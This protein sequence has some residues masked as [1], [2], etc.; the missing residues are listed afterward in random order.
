M[1]KQSRKGK[2]KLFHPDAIATEIHQALFRDFR[3]AQ[4]EYCLNDDTV[5]YALNRQVNEL[6]KKY[7]AT[8]YDKKA[9]EE[10]TYQKFLDVNSHIGA[11][12]AELTEYFDQL[13]PTRINQHTLPVDSIFIRARALAHF[14]LGPTCCLEDVFCR[15][16]HSSGS[17]VGVPY[18]D[19][20]LERKWRLPVTVTERVKPLMSDYLDWDESLTIAVDKRRG[21]PSWGYLS[22]VEG[23]RATTVD[24]NNEIRRFCCPEPTGNMYLQQGLMQLMFERFASVGLN[25]PDLP[26]EHKERAR[27]ASLSGNEATIDWSSAS[28]CVS[29]E[30]LRWLLPAQWYRMVMDLRC[31]VTC[32]N[33]TQVVELNMVSTMG[34]ATTFPLETLVFW[35]LGHAVRLYL[36]GSR[37]LFPEWDELKTVSV[38]GDD[39]I[40]PSYCASLFVEACESVGFIINKEKSFVDPTFRFRESCGGDYLAGYDVRPFYLKAPTSTSLSALEPWLYIIGNSLLQKYI[41]YFGPLSYIYHSF[42]STYFEVFRRFKLKLKLV[43]SY[44]PDDAGFKGGFDLQRFQRLYDVN[45]DVVSRSEQG[46]YQFRYCRF[47]YWQNTGWND[48]LRLATWLKDQGFMPPWR[49]PLHQSPL[50]KRGG[51]VV[52]KAISAHWTLPA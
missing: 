29:T 46:T 20:S 25:L 4:H 38:F 26:D 37:S 41:S 45:Y 49:K 40:V 5:L 52:G 27:L 17:S 36:D 9:A 19:T 13:K 11:V 35:T 39:C 23:S 28:D 42:W 34:N 16:K 22:V 3:E 32:I 18:K 6:Q 48:E 1:K 47:V 50:R 12:N 7:L 24:K 31:D 51:Y 2:R 21:T 10:R 8:D 44:F 15:A 30:I 14:V 43:P 33:N